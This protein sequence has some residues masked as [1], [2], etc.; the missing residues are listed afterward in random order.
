MLIDKG[1]IYLGWEHT[2]CRRKVPE[3]LGETVGKSWKEKEGNRKVAVNTDKCVG[4]GEEA[5][6][7]QISQTCSVK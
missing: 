6:G 5:E 2:R 1:E 4:V 3:L 7:F